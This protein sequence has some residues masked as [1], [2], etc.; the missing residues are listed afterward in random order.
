MRNLHFEPLRFFVFIALIAC[1]LCSCNER[2]VGMHVSLD[3][4]SDLQKD[5]WQ[6]DEGKVSENIRRIALADRPQMTAD[7]HTRTYYLECGRPMWL[8]RRGADSRVDSVLKYVAKVDSFGFS[9][10]DFCYATISSDLARVQNL[11]FD[12]IPDAVNGINRV[13]AR[14]EYSL[15]KAFLRYCEGQRFG[16]ANPYDMFNRLDVRDSDSIHVSY[17]SLYGV[18]TK[19]A[20]REF[21]DEAYAAIAGGY[22]KVGAFMH[23]SYPEN[24]LFPEFCKMLSRPLSAAERRRVFC[25]IERSRWRHGDYPQLH[26]KYVLVNVPTQQL[27]AVDKDDRMTMRIALGSLETKTPLL[28]G[29][30]KRIDFNP[31]WI[32]PKSIIKTSVRHHAGDVGYF[33]RHNYFVR[34]RKTGKEVNPS[35]VTAGMMMS[36]D[37]HVVQRGGKGNALGRI[38]FRFDNDYSIYL[39]DTSNPSVFANRK[40]IVSHGCIRVERPYDLAVFMLADKDERVMEKMKYSIAV[41]YGNDGGD[42]DER[43][44]IDKSKLLRSLSVKPTVPLFITYYTLYPNADGVMVGYD[45]IYG[46]DPVIYAKI[47]NFIKQ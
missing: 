21:L 45:D 32:I 33:E 34:E 10:E 8:S 46:F 2:K 35:L 13:Y 31:Q 40:R 44:V 26:D 16:F 42:A 9:H 24:P 43:P 25:N 30:I 1:A 3:M 37:Y 36:H 17:R 47:Q 19:L 12:T 7:R 18:P 23:A 28:T 41:D 4:F 6:I 15:T 5:Y 27:E 22:E 14:L 20:N 39:H 38:I 29:R 11:D